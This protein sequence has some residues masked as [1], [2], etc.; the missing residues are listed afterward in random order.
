[1]AHDYFVGSVAYPYH[2]SIGGI[3]LND[4]NEVC[5]HYFKHI[6]I[7]G[8][9]ATDLYLLMRETIHPNET[10]EQCL[11]GDLLAYVGSLI[12]T[13]PRKGVTIQ[14][15][16]L[17]FT[18]RLQEGVSLSRSTQDIEGTSEVCWHS[19]DFLI[20]KVKGRQ[21]GGYGI[22]ESEVLERVKSHVESLKR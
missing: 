16:T 21:L 4:R 15:T 18:A 1:M 6:E 9:S 12:T 2:L 14:K 11:A 17:Y 3:L 20:E 5:C 13:F 19:L 7:A 22:D 10:I 8:L